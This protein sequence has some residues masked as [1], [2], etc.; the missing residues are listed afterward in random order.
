M[1]ITNFKPIRFVNQNVGIG[2]KRSRKHF[3]WVLEIDGKELVVELFC[4]LISSTRVVNVNSSLVFSGKKTMF[5]DFYYSFNLDKHVFTIQNSKILTDLII[6]SV[7][8]EK[9]YNMKIGHR[10][11]PQSEETKAHIFESAQNKDFDEGNKE[12]N[13]EGLF[14]NKEKTLKTPDKI[15][16]KTELLLENHLTHSEDLFSAPVIEDHFH[17][18]TI[19]NYDKNKDFNILFS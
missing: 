5:Q 8:F 3:Q 1:E 10:M 9:L 6:D 4:Y 11:Y 2:V 17:E 16:R 14:E 15:E 7:S 19:E 18:K 13:L 12:K